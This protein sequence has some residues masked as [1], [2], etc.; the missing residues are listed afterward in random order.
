MTAAAT[1]EKRSGRKSASELE[2]APG[3]N[4]GR[5]LVEL[6]KVAEKVAGIAEKALGAEE[7]AKLR[8]VVD[9][10]ALR[11]EVERVA[12]KLNLLSAKEFALL[13]GMIEGQLTML[14]KL[15]G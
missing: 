15:R 10:G 5:A 13:E 8:G 6:R 14:I 11:P 4:L 7:G 1:A 9:Q 2:A 3:E 12:K